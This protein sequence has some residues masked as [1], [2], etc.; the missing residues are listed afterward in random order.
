MCIH[1]LVAR[2]S[3]PV[4]LSRR[5]AGSSFMAVS[6]TSTKPDSTPGIASGS[7]TRRNVATGARPSVPDTSSSAGELCSTALR[8]EPTANGAKSTRYAR[9]RTG[10]LWYQ[11]SRN[12]TLKNTNASATTRPG[13]AWATYRLCWVQ[14]EARDCERPVSQPTGRQTRTITA[15]ATVQIHTV[16]H[17]AEARSGQSIP[18]LR[19]TNDHP[20]TTASG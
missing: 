17:A 12:R 10:T 7:V 11:G 8:I 13:S 15:A 16:D 6:S 14:A 5:V 4:G 18:A 19:P 9:I 1:S 2:V 20:A 3:T